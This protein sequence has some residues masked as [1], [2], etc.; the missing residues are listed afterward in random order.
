MEPFRVATLRRK[1]CEGV[2]FQRV[3]YF[4][5]IDYS[6]FVAASFNMYKFPIIILVLVAKTA[7]HCCCCCKHLAKAI[8]CYG[9]FNHA[10]IL[11]MCGW[12]S[13]QVLQS[14]K[15]TEKVYPMRHKHMYITSVE[16][17]EAQ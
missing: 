1:G 3:I 11:C 4:I 15:N 7:A 9:H 17:V 8:T 5:F 16:G 12:S 2:C 13:S 6:L 14:M 10:H